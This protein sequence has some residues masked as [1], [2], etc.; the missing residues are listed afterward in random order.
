ME[1]YCAAGEGADR[2][3]RPDSLYMRY[4]AATAA[5][6]LA[7]GEFVGRWGREPDG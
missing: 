1:K 2:D 6:Y 7:W 5:Y 3:F 4:H